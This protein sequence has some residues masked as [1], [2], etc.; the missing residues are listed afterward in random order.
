MVVP[1]EPDVGVAFPILKKGLALRK[2]VAAVPV[3]LS[4]LHL[5]VVARWLAMK[6]VHGTKGLQDESPGVFPGEL[7][8]HESELH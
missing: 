6:F 2:V 1:S 8:V 7:L 4:D 5:G 3:V